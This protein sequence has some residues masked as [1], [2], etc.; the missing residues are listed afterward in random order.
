MSSCHVNYQPGFSLFCDYRHGAIRK[1]VLKVNSL[2]AVL[3]RNSD[4]LLDKVDTTKRIP[5]GYF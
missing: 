3:A 4:T 1:Q 5:S 2:L